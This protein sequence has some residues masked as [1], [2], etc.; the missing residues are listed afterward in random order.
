[1]SRAFSPR[2]RISM[3]RE[4]YR[5]PSH[6]TLRLARWVSLE[7]MLVAGLAC[8]AGGL[9]VLLVIVGYWSAQQFGQIGNVLPAV[10]GT[11]LMVIGAQNALGGF[12][13]AILSGHEA[14]F[15]KPIAPQEV[16]M[17]PDA[18]ILKVPHG[19]SR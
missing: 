6:W 1:M 14:E 12:L 8:F 7:S 11:S 15:L 5:R 4:G 16:T 2:Q 19:A 3:V 13:L 10:V 17:A 18:A 9:G